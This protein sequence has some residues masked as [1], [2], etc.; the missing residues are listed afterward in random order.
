[1]CVYIVYI[2]THPLGNRRLGT[3]CLGTAG[4]ASQYSD[5]ERC[6]APGFILQPS[7]KN[8]FWKIDHSLLFWSPGESCQVVSSTS[9]HWGSTLSSKRW[10]LSPHL[11]HLNCSPFLQIDDKDTVNNVDTSSSDFTMLQVNC[12]MSQLYPQCSPRFSDTSCCLAALPTK[13][14]YLDNKC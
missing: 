13:V 7:S 10:E 14:T 9:P 8:H 11:L 12:H 5:S 3:W 2:Y 6:E 1:M 4:L